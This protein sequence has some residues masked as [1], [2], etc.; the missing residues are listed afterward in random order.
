MICD[1]SQRFYF[2]AAHTLDR[3]VDADAS[4]RVHGHT[5]HAEV[6]V[7]GPRDP[8]SGMVID[9]GLLRRELQ[10]IRDLL[11]HAFLDEVAGLGPPTLENL[12][13][14]IASQLQAMTP[15]PSAVAVW[16]EA[17]G[18]RCVLRLSARPVRSP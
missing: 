17:S 8:A 4:R 11:D 18:D 6:T 13:G 1:I 14:F 7:S 3:Q 5:Y 16:R 12:C 15:A 2:E 10:R 9:L